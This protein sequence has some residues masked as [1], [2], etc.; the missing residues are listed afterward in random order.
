MVENASTALTQ[1]QGHL[2]AHKGGSLLGT[3]AS[4]SNMG[5]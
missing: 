5:D 3:L 2:P 1:L 4:C